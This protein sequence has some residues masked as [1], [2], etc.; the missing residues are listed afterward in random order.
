MPLG[1]SKS[2]CVQ[3]IEKKIDSDAMWEKPVVRW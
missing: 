3:L 2:A 1:F